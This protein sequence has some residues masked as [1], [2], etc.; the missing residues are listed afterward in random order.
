MYKIPIICN[1][2]SCVV[3]VIEY[4]ERMKKK[5][6]SA[7]FKFEFVF[8]LQLEKFISEILK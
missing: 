8:F 4:T 7:T 1:I 2:I 5:E 6:T 3:A